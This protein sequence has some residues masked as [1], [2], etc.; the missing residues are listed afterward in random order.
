MLV[1]TIKTFYYDKPP[2]E[3]LDVIAQ[4]YDKRH[5]VLKGIL[6]EL[7][8]GYDEEDEDLDVF[9]VAVVWDS[10]RPLLE[11]T[12]YNNKLAKDGFKWLWILVERDLKV[13]L[14]LT[15]MGNDVKFASGIQ[16]EMCVLGLDSLIACPKDH[17]C[18]PS[19]DK[20]KQLY[21]LKREAMHYLRIHGLKV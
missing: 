12:D 11:L 7:R 15:K 4:E 19:S 21:K 13:T 6:A 16:L 8:A 17:D 9:N 3:V 18:G 20:R 14:K 5:D 2:K 1:L 10:L